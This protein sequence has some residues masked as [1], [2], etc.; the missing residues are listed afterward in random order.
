MEK[1]AAFCYKEVICWFKTQD[2]V[3]VDW[4]AEVINWTDFL[5]EYNNI[6]NVT[7]TIYDATASGIIWWDYRLIAVALFP[8]MACSNKPKE[9]SIDNLQAV[10]WVDCF[11]L[12][13]SIGYSA[14]CRMFS[15]DAVLLIELENLT[16]SIA[17][18]TQAINNG[19]SLQAARASNLAQ[20]WEALHTAIHSLKEWRDARQHCVVRAAKLQAN[21][22]YISN[23][24][25]ILETVIE[26]SHGTELDACWWRRRW[27]SGIAQSFGTY[28]LAEQNGAVLGGCIHGNQ[29]M[30]LCTRIEGAHVARDTNMPDATQDEVWEKLEQFQVEEVAGK[31]YKHLW[32]MHFFKWKDWEKRSWIPAEALARCKEL[33]D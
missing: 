3:P 9:M 17:N 27:V 18:W 25:L 10:Q 21:D 15:Q 6:W 33:G 30:W 11:A 28:H 12:R 22:L 32:W 1:V 4:G 29:H 26:Q 13:H 24:A 7:V 14:F 2:S 23:L 16:W 20:W 5:L 8:L 19:V 31:K